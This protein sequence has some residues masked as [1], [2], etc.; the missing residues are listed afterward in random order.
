MFVPT[1]PFL[2]RRVHRSFRT[3]YRRLK[4]VSPNSS[5]AKAATCLLALGLSAQAAIAQGAQRNELSDYTNAVA[6]AQAADRLS[7]LEQFSMSAQPGPL[8]VVIVGED[9]RFIVVA[10][11]VWM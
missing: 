5:A 2:I 7:H 1:V 9:E 6:R 3:P 11:S 8:K 4:T 10:Q